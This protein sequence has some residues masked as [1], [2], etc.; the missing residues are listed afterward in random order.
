MELK[1]KRERSENTGRRG[2]GHQRQTRY[3]NVHRLYTM[4]FARRLKDIA[5]AAII[6]ITI[7]P[8]L[9]HL[10]AV[11]GMKYSGIILSDERA[12]REDILAM[13]VGDTAWIPAISK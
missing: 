12:L 6:L 4:D 10:P 11:L 13:A 5:D 9:Q 1:V 7:L 2:A 3:Q 8:P